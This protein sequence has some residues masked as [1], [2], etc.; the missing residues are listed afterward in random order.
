MSIV[1]VPFTEYLA[2]DAVSS[3]YLIDVLA[4]SPLHAQ[5]F[6]E[7]D[8]DT[9]ALK[10][11]RAFHTALLEPAELLS[12]YVAVP[13]LDGRT[14]E[15]KA[16]KAALPT[17]KE[18][19]DV[20]EMA[21]IQAMVAALRGFSSARTYLQG[22]Y[23]T[24]QSIFWEQGGLKCK[25][26]LD[27]L[28]NG[29]VM[30]LKTCADASAL[31][32]ERSIARYG[33][34]IQA[35]WYMNAARS[36]NLLVSEYVLIAVE[37]EPPFGVQV[38]RLDEGYLEAANEKIEDALAQHRRCI[39]DKVWRGYPDKAHDVLCPAWLATAEYES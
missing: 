33:Y 19:L 34:Y 10:F 23:A 28:G 16:A 15:G 37:S 36:Q 11:G 17:D 20:T 21:R 24:E 5:Y 4:R 1:S 3:H 27:G 13:K 32:F 35:A 22:C 9:D 8:R 2:A 29:Y 26:R 31:A 30:D 39:K 6:R 18:H 25:A 7:H 12:R 14:K 38:F